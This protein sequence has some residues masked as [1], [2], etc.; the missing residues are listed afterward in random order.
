MPQNT[1]T[2]ALLHTHCDDVEAVRNPLLEIEGRLA[3]AHVPGAR[4]DIQR[5]LLTPNQYKVTSVLLLS[6]FTLFNIRGFSFSARPFTAAVWCIF[7]SLGYAEIGNTMA[8]TLH[9]QCDLCS[10][11]NVI[12]FI[13]AAEILALV[14]QTLRLRDNQRVS[15]RCSSESN[16]TSPQSPRPK[17]LQTR[18]CALHYGKRR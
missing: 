17:P 3:L 9:V 11:A 6:P 1:C 5:L 18:T 7:K 10:N 15:P 2:H 14:L 16:R 4:P 13:P 12:I 8:Y